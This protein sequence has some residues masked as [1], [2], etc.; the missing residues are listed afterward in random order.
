ML[1]CKIEKS[2]ET[3]YSLLPF[4]GNTAYQMMTDEERSQY[5]ILTCRY[6]KDVCKEAC[7]LVLKSKKKSEK[8][9]EI[10]EAMIKVE[11]NI[12]AAIYRGVGRNKAYLDPEG[13][14]IKELQATKRLM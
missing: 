10:Q 5:H 4:M 7:D 8:L 3:N 6:Y 9:S 13:N 11:G 12:W 2:G 14:E 1:V